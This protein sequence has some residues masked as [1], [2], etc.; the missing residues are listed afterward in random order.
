MAELRERVHVSSIPY[1][2]NP[3][4]LTQYL[5]LETIASLKA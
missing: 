5:N 4:D 1:Q 2:Q 3:M